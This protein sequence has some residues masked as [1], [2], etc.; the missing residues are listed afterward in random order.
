M[1]IVHNKKNSSIHLRWRNKNNERMVQEIEDFTPY[2]FI[3]S[4]EL[5]PEYF[6]YS[7]RFMG[8]STSRRA[9]LTYEEGYWNNINGERL[10]KVVLQSIDDM[11]KAKDQWDITYEA[12]VGLATRYSVDKLSHIKEYNL[13]KWYFDIETQVGGRYDGFINAIS[14][15]DNYD[16]QYYTLTWFPKEP[17]PKFDGVQ[18]FEDEEDMLNC[19]VRLMENKDPDM[20]IGWYVLGYDIPFII[21]RLIENKI[22]PRKLSPINDIQGATHNKMFVENYSNTA[23]PIKGRICYD[24]MHHFERLWLDSQRGTLA[25]LSL[26]FCSK[27]ILGS[28]MGKKESTK[29]TKDEFFRKAWLEDTENFL[30]YSKIDVELLVRIDLKMNVSENSVALQKLLVCPIENTFHNSLMGSVYFMRN[31]SWKTI[32]GKKGN[33]KKYDAAFVIDP[34]LENTFGFHENVAVFDFK[35]L[36]PSMIASRNISWE[37]KCEDLETG[38]QVDWTTPK[39]LRPH[40]KENSI[41]FSQGE[42]GL[43]PSAVLNLGALRSTY[44]AN[45]TA[46]KEAN[47]SASAQRWDAAQMAVKR[48][49]NAFYGILS[50]DGYGW[51]DRDL[52]QSITA[53]AREAMREVAFKAISLGYKV[54]YGHTDSIF[55]QV[56]SIDDAAK[57]CEELND[58][59]RTEIFDD[60]VELEFEKYC[61]TFFLAKKKNRYCG[62]LSWKE[63]ELLDEPEF[64]VMGFETKKSNETPYAKN[65]QERIL[66]MVANNTSEDLVTKEAKSKYFKLKEGLVDPNLIIKRSR[67]K[68]DLAEYISI[69]GGVAGIFYHNEFIATGDLDKIKNGD[70]FIYYQVDNNS[71]VNYPKIFHVKGVKRRVA[72]IASSSLDKV[73]DEFKP[74]WEKIANAEIIKKITLIYSSMN[75]DLNN[76]IDDNKQKKLKEWW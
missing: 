74:D 33:K 61:K 9:P 36:Y 64:F 62:Y 27:K 76:V 3:E 21:K 25:S 19:F 34:E 30:E 46:A 53:S 47:D 52:A 4:T 17:L 28:S 73:I 24:L 43:L 13:R 14:I 51:A 5:R 45:R 26:D 70:S 75:W 57:L 42:R 8:R 59:I 2:F 50:K 67:L 39:N 20:L 48:V 16:E 58:F 54:H 60:Y 29:F 41:S 66:K 44:K 23:Q 56:E 69:A 31:A 65:F 71:I 35:G 1:I 22:N 49:V 63:N 6:T 37:T 72:Y 38:Y 12:D 55:V 32:T 68:R 11:R 15:Y 7:K 18:V 10:T 40:T